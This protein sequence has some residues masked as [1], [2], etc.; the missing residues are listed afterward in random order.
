M[1]KFF[2]KKINS[3]NVNNL[4][5]FSSYLEK[6]KYIQSFM[7]NITDLHSNVCPCCHAKN[8]L[9]KYG[10][11][12]RN[13]SILEDNDVVNYK[14][15]VQRVFC[16]SCNHSHALLPNF[17]VPYKIMALVSIAQIVQ[18]ASVSS[19]Y[20]LAENIKI[21]M[22]LIYS[23][24]AI[25]IAFFN[26]FRILNN[27]KEYFDATNFNKKYFLMNCIKLSEVNYRLDYF[28]FYNWLLF[29][30]KFRNNISPPITI[31]VSNVPPT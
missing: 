9:I 27:S 5:N 10:T 29:M 8:K 21:S 20:K 14:V 2:N 17:I 22:Q 28:E 4:K 25:V 3:F 6:Q 26:D 23:Y 12:E 19:A 15:V 1:I 16:T 24:I 31:S 30:Q 11:Y 7:P 18:K 13:L